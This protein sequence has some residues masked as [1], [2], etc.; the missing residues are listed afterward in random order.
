[1]RP[2]LEALRELL[3]YL[4]D[5]QESFPAIHVTGTNGKGSTVA[6]IT[7]LLE[8]TGLSVASFTS[9]DLGQVTERFRRG[10]EPIE[11][12]ELADVLEDLKLVADKCGIMASRFELLT[13]AAMRWFSDLAVDVAVVEVGAGGTHDATIVVSSRVAV[14]T[15][16]AADHLDLYGPT[17]ADLA[18]EKAGVIHKDAA[19]V[20]GPLEEAYLPVFLGRPH[21][22]QALWARDF[23]VAKLQ[24][25]LGGSLV[26]LYSGST[27]YE[28]V[29]L[30]MLGAHQ[31]QNAGLAVAASE[32][33]L[34]RPL[35]AEVVEA[36]LGNVRLAGRMEIIGRLPLVIADVAH[37][38]AAARALGE[39]LSSYFASIEPKVAVVGM[40]EDRDAE[41]YLRELRAGCGLSSIIATTPVSPRAK[42]G[43]EVWRAARELGIEA[44]FVE[45][46]EEALELAEGAAASSGMVVVTGCFALVRQARMQ[47]GERDKLGH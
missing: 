44:A 43:A 6:M 47:L 12:G 19:V 21:R 38:P 17:I 32:A 1:M 42:P 30:S 31:A 14:V 8:A 13:A 9:P 28:G 25:A 27:R 46:P 22:S 5:P 23:G 20:L 18:E 39:A 4:G 34:G 37:N 15:N 11:P 33:F 2:S 7:A 36:G 24:V 35:S 29:F 10:Q 26:D 3:R 16:L 45:D 40:L 41:E